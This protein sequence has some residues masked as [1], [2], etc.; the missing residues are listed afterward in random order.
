[1]LRSVGAQWDLGSHG[2]PIE[3]V[4]TAVPYSWLCGVIHRKLHSA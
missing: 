4:L 1:M 2:Y 3:I